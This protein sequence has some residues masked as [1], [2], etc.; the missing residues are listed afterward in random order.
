MKSNFVPSCDIDRID[1]WMRF[2]KGLCDQCR[3]TCCT[4]PVEV[5]I[6]DLVRLG[7]VDAFD[8]EEEPRLLARRLQKGGVVAHFNHR[9]SLFTLV[10][11]ASGDCL[12]LDSQTR[13]C[14]VYDKRPDTCRNHPKVGPRPGYCAFR[15]KNPA[16]Q[17]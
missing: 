13:R 14:T 9:H 3:A 5:R 15:G 11:R 10:R 4:M 6:A 1:T 8:A 2:R 7:V 12:Y 16:P 17:P